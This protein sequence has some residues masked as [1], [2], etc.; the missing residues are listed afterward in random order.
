MAWQRL[1]FVMHIEGEDCSKDVIYNK[2]GR[3]KEQ[4]IEESTG[5]R[6]KYARWGIHGSKTKM[7]LV[8]EL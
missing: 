7:I 5:C 8:I 3:K 6:V 2:M 4:I 1:L